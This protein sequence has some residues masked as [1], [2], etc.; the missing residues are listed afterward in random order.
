MKRLAAIGALL[1]VAAG[2]C[3]GR[4]AAN[5]C[6]DFFAAYCKRVATCR[7]G[8]DVLC[9]LELVGLW[10]GQRRCADVDGLRS[11]EAVNA[12][13]ARIE[14]LDCTIALSGLQQ[15]ATPYCL[16]QFVFFPVRPAPF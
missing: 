15:A 6:T 8:L 9:P 14:T 11:A 5:R 12:C 3:G 13:Q 2:G 10:N 16:E 1:A 4:D 7:G